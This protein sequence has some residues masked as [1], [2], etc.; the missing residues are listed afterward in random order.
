[1]C[2]L[3]GTATYAAPEEKDSD[4]DITKFCYH[5]GK[6]YSKGGQIFSPNRKEQLTCWTNPHGGLKNF[7][8]DEHGKVALS[9]LQWV[10]ETDLRPSKK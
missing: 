8:Q 3:I 7:G 6:A 10:T 5:D 9:P 4:K 1:M 2:A